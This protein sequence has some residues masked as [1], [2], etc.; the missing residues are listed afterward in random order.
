MIFASGM[1]P[2]KI[3]FL[4]DNPFL[5][6]N[7]PSLR[8]GVSGSWLF[9]PTT[10]SGDSTFQL[11]ILKSH[12]AVLLSSLTYNLKKDDKQNSPFEPFASSPKSPE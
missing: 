3:R 12:W 5:A 4:N 11:L 8:H 9:A 2:E 6:R 1:F 10:R 7:V